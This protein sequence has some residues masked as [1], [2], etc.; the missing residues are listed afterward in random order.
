MLTDKKILVAGLIEGVSLTELRQITDARGAVLHMLRS[1]APEFSQF[2]ECYFSE[3]LPGAVKAWKRH[4]AQT[5]NLA[6]PV[7]RILM[8]I[9]D[10]RAWAATRG[11]LQVLQ[12]GRPDAYIRLCVPP[13]VW[14]GFRCMGGTPA[15]LANCADMPHDPSD[16]DLLSMD[17]PGI[18]YSWRKE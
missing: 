14:Y 13:G 4:R 10:D 1:D 15:L 18:P 3:I 16:S 5:Q 17:D 11:Q 8:V 2:G 9:Y 12:L 6:V 7:G